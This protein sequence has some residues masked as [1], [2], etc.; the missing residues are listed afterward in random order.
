MFELHRVVIHEVKKKAH[1]TLTTLDLSATIATQD[2]EIFS[3]LVESINTVY[4]VSTSLKN[5]HFAP[6]ADTVFSTHLKR[7]LEEG[8]DTSFYAFSV[9]AMQALKVLMEEELLATGGFYCFTDYTDH[10]RRCV[11][12]ILL[13][14][15]GGFN[16]VKVAN[17]FTASGTESL[18][19]DKI[20]TGFRLN[21]GIYEDDTDARNSIALITSQQ[22]QLASY[23]RRWVS[24]AEIIT[25]LKNTRELVK[26]VRELPMPVDEDG[27][28]MFPNV[29]AFRKACFN[30]VEDSPGKRVSLMDMGAHFYGE[31]RR[32]ALFEV[33]DQHNIIIDNEFKRDKSVWQKV[34][35]IKV[36]IP[37]VHL[38]IDL[39][40]I[41]GELVRIQN[42][43]IVIRSQDLVQQIR[44]LQNGQ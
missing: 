7:Y 34:V 35:S 23:F 6:D 31:E 37:G 13:R 29:D 27:S 36:S 43:Q 21:V 5:T 14:R 4:S 28:D 24:V 32:R 40:K 2:L 25:N 11:A 1:E 39:D 41:N 42:D 9:Q 44:T 12:V 16:F 22:D 18:N 10:G 3:N 33:A 30:F 8:T 19:F 17:T 15:K 20:A 26:L 38:T